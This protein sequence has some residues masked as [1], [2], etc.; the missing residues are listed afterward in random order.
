MADFS[1]SREGTLVYRTSTT[2]SRQLLWRDR[3]GRELGAVGEEEFF[4][5][6]S[7]SPQGSRLAV[8]I[9]NQQG[10]QSDVWIYDLER[11]AKSRFTFDPKNDNV[12]LWSPDGSRI[13]FNSN[14]SG[15]SL[16]CTSR[17]PPARVT[18]SCC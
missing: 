13:A 11:G 7:V 14:R 4:E 8:G 15:S 2:I 3:T 16:T 12:P 1:A 5:S 6:M 9:R 18:S 10:D 17:T